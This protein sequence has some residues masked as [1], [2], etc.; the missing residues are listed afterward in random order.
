MTFPRT[1]AEREDTVVDA[2][3]ALRNDAETILANTPFLLT[4]CSSDLRYV[5]VSEA[6]AKMLGQRPEE[7]VGKEIVKIMGETGFQT[8]LP[9]IKAVLAG[10]RVE[11]ETDVHFN[12]VGVR[13]L[14]VIYTPDKDQFG[15][16][17]G[18]IASIIDCHGTGTASAASYRKEGREMGTDPPLRFVTARI[19]VD[20]LRPTPLGV[21][22][23]IRG[24]VEELEGRKVVVISTVSA[25]GEVCA[26][27]RVVAVRMPEHMISKKAPT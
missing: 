20:Y 15:N 12:D 5:F 10:Q 16:V 7:L 14:Q 23:E 24:K 19:Q 26:R 18:W 17:L 8:I 11:Y 25:E 13:L 1:L 21:P 22:L 9:H 27:G 6:Y 2:A 3:V 4:R